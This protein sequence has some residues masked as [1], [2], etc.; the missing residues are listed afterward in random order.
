MIK[1]NNEKMSL[2]VN[3]K[4]IVT[5]DITA[6]VY[7]WNSF[8]IIQKRVYR[9]SQTI[10]KKINSKIPFTINDFS[11][12][13]LSED[14]NKDLENTISALNSAMILYLE[15]KNIKDYMQIVQLIPQSFNE[16]ITVSFTDDEL[17]DLYQVCYDKHGEFFCFAKWIEVIMRH[18]IEGLRNSNP[19]KENIEY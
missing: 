8:E 14:F 2:D 7:W 17:L 13:V 5:V 10:I 19:I 16:T 11:C 3:G 12:D 18:I 1:M 6:P 4:T 15:T 9:Q